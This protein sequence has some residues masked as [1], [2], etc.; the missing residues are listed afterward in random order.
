MGISRV[1]HTAT[2]L[3]SGKVLVTGG[4]VYYGPSLVTTEL[5]DPGTNSWSA[6]S[7]MATPRDHHGAVLLQ[8]GQVLVIGGQNQGAALLTSELYR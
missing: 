2:L 6:A 8:P 5:Y 7:S 1:G 4:S 3:L